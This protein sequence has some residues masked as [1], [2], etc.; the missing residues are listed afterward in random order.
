MILVS[1]IL[2]RNTNIIS[3]YKTV[4]RPILMHVCEAWTLIRKEENKFLVDEIKFS[5]RFW[6]ESRGKIGS[7]RIR[8]NQELKDIVS[9]PNIIRKIKS[10]RITWLGHFERMSAHRAVKRAFIGRPSGPRRV[11]RR[12]YRPRDEVE[13]DLRALHVE[14][15]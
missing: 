13:T 14:N 12:K 9:E 1:K 11:S 2:R 5:A 10:A 7:L 15:W 3:V 6:D 4:I 8:R